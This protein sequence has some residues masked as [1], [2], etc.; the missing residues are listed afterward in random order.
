M[1]KTDQSDISTCP[2]VS[3]EKKFDTATLNN[4]LRINDA[5]HVINKF[6]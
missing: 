2:S 5:T 3:L 4:K 6:V 1:D